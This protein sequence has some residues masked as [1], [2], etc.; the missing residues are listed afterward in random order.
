VREPPALVAPTAVARLTKVSEQSV[1]TVHEP[2]ALVAAIW[3]AE[4]SEQDIVTMH[5]PAALVALAVARGA[6][7]SEQDIVTVHEPAALVALAVARGADLSEQ[8][9]VTAHELPALAS[10]MTEC[11]QIWDQLT[12]MTREEWAEACR[13]VDDRLLVRHDTSTTASGD[14]AKDR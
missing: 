12:H 1:F 6:D 14:R 13:R 11:E 2:P 10:P 7:L 9:V 8:N 4:V 5:E 3:I